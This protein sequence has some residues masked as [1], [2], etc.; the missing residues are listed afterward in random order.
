M[1]KKPITV[2]LLSFPLLL[3]PL[4]ADEAANPTAKLLREALFAEQADRD[5]AT[6]EKGYREIIKKFESDRAYAATAILRLA[7]ILHQRGDIAEAEKW[8]ARVL[9]EFPDQEAIVKVAAARLGDKATDLLGARPV[10]TNPQ[11][12]EIERI[13]K[14]LEQ[15]PDLLNTPK[16][17]TTPLTTAAAK[18]QLE[19][20]EFLLSKGAQVNVSGISPSALA[21]AVKNGH[22]AIVA[23]LLKAESKLERGLLN[24]AVQ[25]GNYAISE[26]LLKAGANPNTNGFFHLT[27][28]EIKDSS[29]FPSPANESD[30]PFTDTQIVDRKPENAYDANPEVLWT[31]L[32]IAT[33]YR[34]TKLTD[35]LLANGAKPQKENDEYPEDLRFAIIDQNTKLVVKLLKSGADPDSHW[36]QQQGRLNALSIAAT[37][38]NSE[39][40]KQLIEAGADVN[41]AGPNDG[42]TPLFYAKGP[43]VAV[44]IAAGAD[45]N[46]KNKQ[47][48]TPLLE[49]THPA[50]AKALIAAGA[51]LYALIDSGYSPIARA[52][53][54]VLDVLLA[55]KPDLTRLEGQHTAL[56][57][58]SGQ[59]SPQQVKRIEK[60]IAAGGDP[61]QVDKNAMTPL[62]IAV[63]TRNPDNVKALIA[64]GANPNGVP[65]SPVPLNLLSSR[66]SNFELI[67]RALVDA[68]A[69]PNVLDS[70]N[71]TILRKAAKSNDLE[72]VRYLLEKGAALEAAGKFA[73]VE[74][75][76]KSTTKI[77]LFL[78]TYLQPERRHGTIR[79]VAPEMG[80]ISDEVSAFAPEGEKLP[81]CPY[82]ILEAYAFSSETDLSFGE[83][84][85][86]R[87]GKVEPLKVDLRKIIASGDPAQDLKLAWGDLIQF[88]V[89]KTREE[90]AVTKTGIKFLEDHLNRQVQFTLEGKTNQVHLTLECV[91]LPDSDLWIVRRNPSQFNYIEGN[92][93]FPLRLMSVNALK[94]VQQFNVEQDLYYLEI[95]TVERGGRKIEIPDTGKSTLWLEPDDI[96]FLQ[97][98]AQ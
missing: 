69:D 6:A 41:I 81:E 7:E 5:L 78:A 15:S 10:H 48:D 13:A 82:S 25:S 84:T 91:Q 50:K 60:L 34:F 23:R 38:G 93:K 59:S 61:N 54:E 31:P 16:D 39:I 90:A 53:L 40:V 51:D 33:F 80:R 71:E 92:L 30:D 62:L 89:A 95:Q 85:I 44:L 87:E 42:N 46:A 3:H 43:T 20:I 26:L 36:L 88:S 37:L 24:K 97:K 2:L 67:V 22:L 74:A 72:T 11:T 58:V 28:Q 70:N 63:S 94:L 96:I 83:V 79:V 57:K 19:V 75:P 52:N 9:Q 56:G 65:N 17:G 32:E 18:G 77:E 12:E 66:T 8:F 55:T 29:S 86:W 1:R 27:P 98:R 45:P 49:V 76:D 21:A 64:G 68:G 73:F 35:L 47:G 14:L 4:L